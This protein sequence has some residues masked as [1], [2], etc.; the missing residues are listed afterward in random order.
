MPNGQFL[1]E[2]FS[3]P[4]CSWVKT[5]PNGET[6]I[7]VAVAF[8]AD[9]TAWADAGLYVDF[10]MAGVFEPFS[11]TQMVEEWSTNNN[12]YLYYSQFPLGWSEG[13]QPP[14]TFVKIKMAE[15]E[16]LCEIGLFLPYAWLFLG[17]EYG[18]DEPANFYA[19]A[20]MVVDPRTDSPAPL[21]IFGADGQAYANMIL[22]ALTAP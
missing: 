9:G 2:S 14:E 18:F 22:D 16:A 19:P 12:T 20:C 10:V 5:H 1:Y 15:T 8:E 11:P 7:E 4:T 13:G 17:S 21:V 6:S 3:S